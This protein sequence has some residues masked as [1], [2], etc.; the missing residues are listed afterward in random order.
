M[1]SK[2]IQVFKVKAQELFTCKFTKNQ[3]LQRFTVQTGF[4]LDWTLLVFLD[5]PGIKQEVKA[6]HTHTHKT[7]P[8]SEPHIATV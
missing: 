6:P 3:I 7:P 1:K 2:H 4:L 8:H 5:G